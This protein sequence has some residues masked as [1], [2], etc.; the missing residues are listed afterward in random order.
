MIPPTNPE[1]MEHV[2]SVTV[3]HRDGRIST[4]SVNRPEGPTFHLCRKVMVDDLASPKDETVILGKRVILMP[5]REFSAR[6]YLYLLADEVFHE[7][8]P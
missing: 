8:G 6:D 3:Y 1:V 4:V 7:E 2:P 5:V